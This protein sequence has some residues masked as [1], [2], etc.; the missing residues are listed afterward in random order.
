MAAAPW[1]TNVGG[2]PWPGRLDLGRLAA[3]AEG[4]GAWLL[5]GGVPL[6]WGRMAQSCSISIGSEVSMEVLAAAA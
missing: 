3:A 5:H 2:R 6:R 1:V 4:G